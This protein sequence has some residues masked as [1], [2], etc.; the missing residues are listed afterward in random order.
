M[1]HELDSQAEWQRLYERYHAMSDGELLELAAGIDDLTEVAA[2]VLRREMRD[3]RL[4]VEAPAADAPAASTWWNPGARKGGTNPGETA[5]MTFN[6]AIEAGRACEFLE[7]RAI[8][9]RVED[10]SRPQSGLRSFN[11]LPPV[12]LNLVVKREDRER[13]MVVLRETMGL[14]PLRE[15]V[16]A[17]APV[18]DGTVATLGDFARREDAEGVGRVLDDARVWHRIVANPDGTAEDEN[19]YSLEVREVDLMRAGELVEKAMDLPEA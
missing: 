14:F 2:D 15:V 12:M 17:D 13:A 11:S 16:V 5:L 7:Q 9:F 3:R 10:V 1:A 8:D 19:A 18:D 4:Q 6:D